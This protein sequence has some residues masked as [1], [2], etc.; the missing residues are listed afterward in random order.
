[1]QH[2]HPR[3]LPFLL[4]NL[5]KGF[6]TL[7]QTA[8]VS[9]KHSFPQGG[10]NIWY[11]VGANGGHRYKSAMKVGWVCPLCEF[12]GVFENKY[13]LGKHL[14]WDHREVTVSWQ[15]D[16]VGLSTSSAG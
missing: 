5:R 6:R 4:R 3:Q 11:S 10:V 1:M 14:E 2:A 8:G 15:N 13:M 12:H 16:E 7:C 9:T